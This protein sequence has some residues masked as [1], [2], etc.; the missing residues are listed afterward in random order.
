[1][2]VTPQTLIIVE[3][4]KDGVPFADWDAESKV[5]LAYAISPKNSHKVG[6]RWGPDSRNGLRLLKHLFKH[7]SHLRLP[8]ELREAA[9]SMDEIRGAEI[10]SLVAVMRKELHMVT[11]P[12]ILDG[13]F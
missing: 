10:S 1:M 12:Y 13:L 4:M 6:D 7:G 9:N 8:L 2:H 3:Y 11:P 5:L